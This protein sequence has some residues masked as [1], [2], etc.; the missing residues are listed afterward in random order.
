MRLTHFMTAT[1]LAAALAL[2]VASFAQPATAPN[3]TAPP[4][5]ATAPK[6]AAP[7]ATTT[8]ATRHLGAGEMRASKMIGAAVYDQG[9]QKL[10]T[11]ADL[12]VDKDGRVGDVVIGL[13]DRNVAVKMADVKHGKDNHLVLNASKEALKQMATYDLAEAP[14]HSGTSTQK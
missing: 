5:A 3:P 4:A 2:P 1:A 8:H 13:G 10:G 11:I 7:A 6:A 12:V 9:D 14:A